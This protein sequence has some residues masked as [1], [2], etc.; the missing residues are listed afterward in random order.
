[1]KKLFLLNFMMA[2]FFVTGCQTI[3]QKTAEIIK[4]E[5]TKMEKFIGQSENE[6]KIAMGNP[7]DVITND[8]GTRF[9][10]YKSKK[11]A[12]KCERKFEINNNSLV[13]GFSYRGCF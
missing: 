3:D 1:M 10:I 4:K 6:L 7:D 13:T 12:I 2:F 11:Y 5:N 9:L 8:K